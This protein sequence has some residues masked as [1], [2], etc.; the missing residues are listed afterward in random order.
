MGPPQLVIDTDIIIDYLR[1]HTTIL[2]TA[3][4]NYRCAITAITLYELKAVAVRSERQVEL[5]EQLFLVVEVLA[6]DA[7][8]ANLAS[9][10]WRTLAAQ[11]QGIGLPDTFVAG[12]CLAYDLPLLT[13][14]L[15]HYQRVPGLKLFTPDDLES[16]SHERSA[17]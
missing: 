13:R 16:E 15:A 17:V 7:Q 4:L 6:F 2:Q 14:N 8:A 1:R 10:V 11:G 9:E 3:L 5:L 12:T